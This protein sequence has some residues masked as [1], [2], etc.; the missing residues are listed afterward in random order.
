MQFVALKKINRFEKYKTKNSRETLSKVRQ[1]V[2]SYHLQL[3]NL[4]YESMHLHKAVTKCL[5]FKYLNL[6]LVVSG[7]FN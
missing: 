6:F 5:E 4:L 2:D 1:Q 3:Q 7:N